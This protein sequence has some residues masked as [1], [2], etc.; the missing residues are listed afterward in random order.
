V[1]KALAADW[2]IE[3]SASLDRTFKSEHDDE[4]LVDVVTLDDE[5]QT[6]VGLLV[7]DAEG[8][9]VQVLRGATRILSQDRP[10]VIVEI[11][12]QDVGPLQQIVDEHDLVAAEFQESGI[13]WMSR[14]GRARRT[15]RFVG[16][17][18]RHEYWQLL[19]APR[20]VKEEVTQLVASAS[21]SV[22]G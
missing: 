14:V 12:Q 21:L 22:E 6:H 18:T 20:E 17:E 16:S 8:V 13:A 19:L 9:D 10:L 1:P 11:T 3:T 4:F 15:E 5:M 2:P 7:V